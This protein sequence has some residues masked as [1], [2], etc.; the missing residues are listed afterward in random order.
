MKTLNL[1]IP[2][3]SFVDLITNSSSEVYVEATQSTINGIKKLVDHLLKIGGSPLTTD[4]LFTFDVVFDCT[5]P[6]YED[7]PMTKA[8]IKA[9]KAELKAASEAIQHKIDTEETTLETRNKL[10][11]ELDAL[12]GWGFGDERDDGYPRA[13]VRVTVKSDNPN[14][15]AAAKILSNLTGLFNI[16]AGY[17]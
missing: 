15:K 4:E 12:D 1:R 16:E 7:V 13:S 17:N 2:V 6:D 3:H 11:E 9:K 10:Q 14:A 5:D 8:E